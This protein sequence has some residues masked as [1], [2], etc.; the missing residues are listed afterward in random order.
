V[1]LLLVGLNHRT[2]PVA[3]RERLAFAPAKL[4]EATCNL[5]GVAQVQE[6][7]IL[8]TCNRVEI[9]SLTAQPDEAAP[10]IRQFLHHHHRLTESVDAHLYEL[11]DA[12]CVRHLWEVVCGLDS[13]V[14]GETEI[15]GQVKNAYAA[16]QLA[17]ATGMALNRLFQKAFAGA[18]QIRTQTGIARGSTSVGNVAVDLA[19]KIFRELKPC[20]VMV[21]G[22]GE[23]SEATAK[24]LS[25][26]GAGTLLVCS[27]TQERAEALAGQLG[28]RTISYD[29]WPANFP[30]VDI[31]ISATAAPHP[32]I[33]R[34]K[35]LPLM[36]LRRQRP[37]F[38]IDLAVPRD[39]E[40]A[41]GELENVYLYDMDDLQTIAQENRAARERELAAAH[42]LIAQHM[43]HYL[44][45]FAANRA[46]LAAR[47]RLAPTLQTPAIAT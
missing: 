24:A 46:A 21:V 18:K 40:R 3:V 6:A 43:A 12:D 23:I 22:T 2:A 1:N 45:W 10:A 32:I 4:G 26:R 20:T 15:F 5:L 25:S 38:L 29:D 16:A 13:M 19:E 41:C 9:Y 47:R 33:T 28:G 7:A 42:R 31:V 14:L 34:E 17:G 44:Q 30:I 35:L 37:L 36:K 11:R 27:R 39:V 8:S